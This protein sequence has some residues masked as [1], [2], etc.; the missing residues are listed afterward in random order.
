M[1]WVEAITHSATKQ[2]PRA[3]RVAPSLPRGRNSPRLDLLESALP[4]RRSPAGAWRWAGPN[5]AAR[6]EQG[7]RTGVQNRSNAYV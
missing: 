6:R 3:T 1:E 4:R 7:W 2:R 5:P